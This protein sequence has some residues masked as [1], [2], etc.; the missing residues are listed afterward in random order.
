MKQTTEKPVTFLALSNA[1]SGSTYLQS[2]ISAIEGV[3]CDYEYSLKAYSDNPSP[4]RRIIRHGISNI[5]SD[6][7]QHL[8]ASSCVGSKLV[9][10]LYEFLSD[11]EVL[12]INSSIPVEIKIIHLTR[13]YWDLLKSNLS[14]G[15]VHD[16]DAGGRGLDPTSTMYKVLAEFRKDNDPNTKG[17]FVDLPPAALLG[18]LKN[19]VRN[20][21]VFLEIARKNESLLVPYEKINLLLGSVAAFLGKT[22]STKEIEKILLSPMLKKLPAIPDTNMAQEPM[23]RPVADNCYLDLL[24]GIQSGLSGKEILKSQLDRI[25]KALSNEIGASG[26]QRNK[27]FKWPWK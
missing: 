7:I 26:K 22:I 15:V 1:R 16:F 6:I 8:P 13:N 20:D 4:N 10:P 5:H 23:L 9:L 21:F 12:E 14:R 25:N 2:L 19:L 18:Y 17:K 11:E 27:W 24:Q 3:S